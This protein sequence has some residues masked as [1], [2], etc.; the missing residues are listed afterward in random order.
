MANVKPKTSVFIDGEKVDV[1]S[2]EFGNICIIE[3]TAG[4]NGWK[5]GDNGHGC[6]T[7]L[8]IKNVAS[9][10]MHCTVNGG[11]R[12]QAED[13]II[14]LGGDAELDVFTQALS[15]ALSTIGASVPFQP[16]YEPSEKERKQEDFRSMIIAL[17]RHFAD[18]GSMRHMSDITRA[19]HV[20]KITQQQFFECG[21]NT[22]AK[23]EVLD[24]ILSKEYCNELYEYVLG[25]T[26]DIPKLKK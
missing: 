14:D 21:L 8:R 23:S 26:N 4:T 6:R 18:T 5:G 24:A 19:Y 17:C 20:S 16:Y 11:K 2:K 7:Y 15:F 10:Y 13:I 1:K 25:H 9:T 12:V 22:I 3:A